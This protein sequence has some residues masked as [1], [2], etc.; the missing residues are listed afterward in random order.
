[1]A[2]PRR[3][4]KWTRSG[5]G[6]YAQKQVRAETA[7]IANTVL[8]MSAKRAHIAMVLNVLAAS[9]I[10]SQDLEDLPEGTVETERPAP[11]Q[12]TTQRTAPQGRPRSSG[13]HGQA[14]DSQVRLIRAK[15]NDA[16][17]SAED[18]CQHFGVQSITELPFNKVNEALAFIAAPARDAA[19][20][21]AD[22][23]ASNE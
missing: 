10:F 21:E 12:R 15:L 14:T 6:A 13:G 7:D 18:L 8:K 20:T 4:T 17:M 9:D 1:V 3:R 16:R 22:A 2:S 19:P 11:R 5:N 23:G